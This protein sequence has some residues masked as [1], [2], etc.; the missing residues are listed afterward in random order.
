MKRHLILAVILAGTA[1]AAEPDRKANTVVL[2]ETVVKNLGIETAEAEERTFEETVFALGRI[3]VAPGHRAVV[4]SRVP[5]RALEVKAHIDTRVEKGAEVVVLESRQPGDPPP[6]IKLLAPISGLV[7]EVKVVPG[8]PVNVDDSLIEIVDL[9]DVHAMAAVPEHLAATLKPGMKARIRVAALPEREFLADLAHIGAEVNEESGTLEAAFHVENADYAL[10]PGMRAEFSLIIAERENVMTIPRQ[11]LGGDV[12]GR[13]V[14]IKDYELEHAFVKTPIRLGTQND[15]FVEVLE[16][17]LPGDEVV[18]KGAY[19][20]AFSGQGSVSLKEALDAAHGH[21]HN[22]DGSEMTREQ[23]A[24]QGAGGAH[25][26]EHAHGWSG[27][28]KFFA[29]TSAVLFLLLLA[30]G[31]RGRR[32]DPSAA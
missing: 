10:R 17:L 5:G 28:T 16:G 26:H 18:T 27:A 14:F 7:A 1:W 24:A 19:S 4:S 23:I 2:N 31:A 6:T 13:Y 21:P 32:R 30:V 8:Q 3:K 25:D 22:E 9:S 20:L 12:G 29:A 11:A 15:Q